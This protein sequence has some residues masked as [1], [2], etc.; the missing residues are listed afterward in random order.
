M[1]RSGKYGL[2]ENVRKMA[3]NLLFRRFLFACNAYLLRL[4]SLRMKLK[5]EGF[6]PV[7]QRCPI[8]KFADLKEQLFAEIIK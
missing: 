3:S 4:N 8:G 1:T 6:V 5:M 7:L 2:T